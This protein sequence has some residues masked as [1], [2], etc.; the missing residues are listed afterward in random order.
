MIVHFSVL[1]NINIKRSN[2]KIIRQAQKKNNIE[3]LNIVENIE[4][5]DGKSNNYFKYNKNKT[6]GLASCWGLGLA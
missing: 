5:F 4:A 2:K 6:I 1:C 3:E